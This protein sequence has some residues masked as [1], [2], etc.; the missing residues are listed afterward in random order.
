[1]TPPRSGVVLQGAYPPAEFEDMVARI[2]AL[3]QAAVVDPQSLASEREAAD[4][5][6]G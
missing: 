6:V 1:M 3:I 2:D 5:V 4:F